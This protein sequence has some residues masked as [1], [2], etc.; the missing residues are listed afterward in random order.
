[1][2]TGSDWASHVVLAGPRT[3]HWGCP[4]CGHADNWASRIRCQGC[5]A[6]APASRIAAAK[7]A[8]KTPAPYGHRQ[9]QGQ[10]AAGPPKPKHD[11]TVAQLRKELQSLRNQIKGSPGGSPPP[12]ATDGQSGKEGDDDQEAPD[13]TKI[14]Q[15]IEALR[16]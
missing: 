8:A 1:M 13:A 10:W 15:Q 11:D 4:K 9:P 5:N 7:A 12:A 16:A 2:A 6:S 14:H 3:P